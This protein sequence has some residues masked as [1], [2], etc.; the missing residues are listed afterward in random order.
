[1]STHA[2]TSSALDVLL[3]RV[4]ETTEQLDACLDTQNWAQ[5]PAPASAAMAR[6]DEALQDLIAAADADYTAVIREALQAALHDGER[7]TERLNARRRELGRA[8]LRAQRL[9]SASL[10]YIEQ[11]GSGAEEG[12]ISL[13]PPSRS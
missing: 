6:R 3:A 4:Q 11:A 7:F 10:Q 12:G 1:M 8:S 2:T 5:N 13:S 9:T